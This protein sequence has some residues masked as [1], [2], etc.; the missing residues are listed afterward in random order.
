M[1]FDFTDERGMQWE[2]SV[3]CAHYRINAETAR[4]LFREL[5]SPTVLDTRDF[6][7]SC[8]AWRDDGYNDKAG[9]REG[10]CGLAR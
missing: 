5:E 9:E 8:A 3:F 6:V 1:R 7:Q 4:K 2:M 10:H